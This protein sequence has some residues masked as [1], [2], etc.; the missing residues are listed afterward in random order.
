MEEDGTIKSTMNEIVTI[1]MELIKMQIDG[2]SVIGNVA[3]T[4]EIWT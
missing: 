3:L 2:A 1:T 4:D